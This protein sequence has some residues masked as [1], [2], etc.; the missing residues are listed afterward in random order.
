MFKTFLK[1]V[2][3]IFIIAIVQVLFVHKKFIDKFVHSVVNSSSK[4]D[5]RSILSPESACTNFFQ[6]GKCATLKKNFCLYH[7]FHFKENNLDVCPPLNGL[8]NYYKCNILQFV[9]KNTTLR[10]NKHGYFFIL[11]ILL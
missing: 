1:I 7:L 4:F 8:F 5:Y 3:Y 10:I 11:I 2:K 9:Y 6:T